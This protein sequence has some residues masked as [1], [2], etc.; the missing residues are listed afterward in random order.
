MGLGFIRLWLLTLG[1]AG[2]RAAYD[3]ASARSTLRYAEAAYCPDT[4]VQKWDCDACHAVPQFAV[5]TVLSVPAHDTHGFVGHD[6]RA[7]K[8]VV[9]FRGTDPLKLDAWLVDL[10]SAVL[11]DYSACSGCK[12]GH[13]FLGAFV[14]VRN[15]TLDAVSRLSSRHPAATMLIT[16]HSLGGAYATLLAAELLLA[17]RKL[18]MITYGQPRI[19]NA[20][21]A[22]TLDKR[23]AATGSTSWR[24]VHYADPVPHLPP[25]VLDFRHV[26]PE[27]HYDELNRHYQVCDGSGEDP[28]CA[29][30]IAVPLLITDPMTYFGISL[31]KSFLACNL[32]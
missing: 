10:K 19:G 18:T 15:K 6:A 20:A 14:E 31:V 22:S 23:L 9:S 32:R 24:L 17:H 25:E 7:D 4:R 28:Q 1:I 27:V 16:G 12:V 2:A 30:G 13:G 11:D 21:F 3:D 29:D 26:S 8:I 5:E